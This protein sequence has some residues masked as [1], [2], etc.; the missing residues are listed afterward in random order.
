SA[1]AVVDRGRTDGSEAKAAIEMALVD[2]KAR[3]LGLPVHALLGGRV[4]DAI[5]LNAWIGTVAPEQAAREACAWCERGFRTAKIKISGATDEGF[6][7]VA[8]VRAAGGTRM[9]LRADFNERRTGDGASAFMPRLE[10]HT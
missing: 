9:A 5:T 2:L 3:A 4:K 6:E 1:T 8:A 7:R 10:P